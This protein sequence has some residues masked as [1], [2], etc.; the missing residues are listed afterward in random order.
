MAENEQKKYSPPPVSNDSSSLRISNSDV[1]TRKYFDSLL[2]EM[3]LVDSVLASTETEFFGEKLETPV[4]CGVIG[5]YDDERTLLRAHAR[6]AKKTGT[7]LWVNGFMEPEHVK[8]CIDEDGAKVVQIV[9]PFQDN[10]YFISCLQEGEAL[11]CVAV[12]ADIDH[13]YKKNGTYDNMKGKDLGGK[14]EKELAEAVQSVNVPFIAKGVLSVSDAVKCKEAGVA[15]II[16]SHHHNIMD[17]SVPPLMILPEIRKAVGD[18]YPIYVDCGIESGADA[19]KA[20]ALGADGVC[21]ARAIMKVLRQGEDAIVD[22]INEIN[23]ELRT[24]LSRTGSPDISHIDPSVIHQ[25]P[26]SL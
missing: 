12:G 1:F 11:G 13:A 17:Y 5:G 2:V 4:M 10:D 19:F 3:R 16:L 22:K 26:M 6:A 25:I 15:G 21:V 23:G 18:D 8:A 20:L 24:F 9:K 7:I 14:S